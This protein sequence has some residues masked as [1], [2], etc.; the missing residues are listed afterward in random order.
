M[1]EYAVVGK[2]FEKLESLWVQRLRGE[3]VFKVLEDIVAV[4]LPDALRYYLLLF[5][6]SRHLG[7]ADLGSLASEDWGER[8]TTTHYCIVTRTKQSLLAVVT[9][10]VDRWE[11]GYFV[12]SCIV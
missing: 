7:N 2:C 5:T 1:K 4:Q 10:G 11:F 12:T 9:N 6:K 8:E 3:S